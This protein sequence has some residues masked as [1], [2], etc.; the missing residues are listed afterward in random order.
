MNE[1]KE[2]LQA[3]LT[4]LKNTLESGP[5]QKHANYKEQWEA[6]LNK[7]ISAVEKKISYLSLLE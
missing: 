6:W 4:K 1:K 3:Y 7:E 2:K 5:G